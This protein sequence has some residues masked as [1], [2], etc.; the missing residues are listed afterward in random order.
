MFSFSLLFRFLNHEW[1]LAAAVA[2][3][4]TT[5]LY[6]GRL[7]LFPVREIEV[8]LL[9]WALFVPVRGLELSGFMRMLA[10]R[11][12]ATGRYLASSL[13]L[14]TFLLAALVTNDAALVVVTPL[15]M[16]LRTPG[17]ARLVILEALAA[18]AGSALTPFGNPQNLYIF[19]KYAPDI[20]SFMGT[21]APF[22]LFSLVLLLV[23]ATM[24][25]VRAA[26]PSEGPAPAATGTTWMHVGLLILAVLVILRALPIWTLLLTAGCT[27]LFDRR[28]LQV[29]YG[30]LLTF[31][32][33]FALSDNLRMMLSGALDTGEHVF[34]LSAL[35]SQVMSNVP[36]TLLF[37]RFTDDWQAL[38]WGVNVGG[39]GTLIASFANLIAW[40]AFMNTEHDGA[41]RRLF[42]MRFLVAGLMMFLATAILHWLML[43]WGDQ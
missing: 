10:I 30:L 11:V 18:N 33:F 37:S 31:A 2:G 19:W 13:V 36:A 4:V 25:P 29:D 8:L 22:S 1:P 23:A 17:R 16:G 12:E 6:L 24:L 5:S 42:A 7:P 39:Y 27:V 40:R 38:L 3:L 34:M 43:Q 14:L 28:S 26:E 41:A 35:A 20:S 9:L 21:I 15:T 32:A